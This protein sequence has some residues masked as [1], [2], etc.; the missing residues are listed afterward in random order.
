M[1]RHAA[2]DGVELLDLHAIR[3]VLLIFRCDVTR[4][5]GLARF[6]VL[7]TL[8]DYLDAIASFS[9]G[10]MRLFGRKSVRTSI[11]QYGIDSLLIHG[12]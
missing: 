5:S 4:S 7:G 8:Q 3:S 6:L 10:S 12:F 2:K 9:H 1:Q 11:G